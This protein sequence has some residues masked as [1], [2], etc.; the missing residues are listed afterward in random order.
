MV[1]KNK[2]QGEV[3]PY[4]HGHGQ[5]F[6]SKDGGT[7]IMRVI[8]F[9]SLRNPGGGRA[10]YKYNNLK[11]SPLSHSKSLSRGKTFEVGPIDKEVLGG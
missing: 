10:V 9:I 4:S 1:Q 8:N 2:N 11:W 5:T 7:L 6:G 3:G